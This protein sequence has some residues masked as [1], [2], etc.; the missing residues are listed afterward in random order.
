MLG[1]DKFRPAA[2]E[3]MI[4]LVAL[5]VESARS[6]SGTG[7]ALSDA[8]L[9]ALTGASITTSSSS[10]SSAAPSPTQL[11]QADGNAA[12]ANNDDPSPKVDVNAES[13]AASRS[14]SNQQ[15]QQ[16]QSSNLVQLNK[17]TKF[18]FLFQQIK[19]NLN[20]KATVTIIVSLVK[21]KGELAEPIIEMIFKGK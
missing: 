21:W 6:P 16:Q 13:K 1:D 18:P 14:P 9:S 4:H 11:Q 15:Q 20:L 2:L 12:A 17:Q 5:L 19:D 3:K 7:F 8:D 10:P